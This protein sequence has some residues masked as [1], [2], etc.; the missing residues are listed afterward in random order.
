[1]NNYYVTGSMSP[2]FIKSFERPKS[3]AAINNEE[4][5]KYFTDLG[6]KVLDDFS[7]KTRE[8]W[9]EIYGDDGLICQIDKGV[10]LKDILEDLKCFAEGKDGTSKLDYTISMPDDEYTQKFLNHIKNHE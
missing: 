10:P 7:S 8:C 1:M 3:Q 2:E 9:H 5:Y 6:Y 4:V